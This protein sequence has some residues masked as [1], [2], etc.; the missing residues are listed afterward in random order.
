MNCPRVYYYRYARA[1]RRGPTQHEAASC[2]PGFQAANSVSAPLLRRST[3][4]EQNTMIFFYYWRG[5]SWQWHCTAQRLTDLSVLACSRGASD[6]RR[7]Y[8]IDDD[9]TVRACAHG[10]RA[11]CQA[12]VPH[13][14]RG[15]D[16]RATAPA[17]TA[18][19]ASSPMV[20]TPQVE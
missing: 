19:T 18:Q 8:A 14:S 10:H 6:G 9:Q 17:T 3:T 13:E 4:I 5:T 7:P 12:P 20:E 15:R 2:H 1:R 16:R 11:Q